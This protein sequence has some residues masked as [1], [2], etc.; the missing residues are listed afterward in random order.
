MTI[1]DHLVGWA[2]KVG[3]EL[4][5]QLKTETAIPTFLAK[6]HEIT[7]PPLHPLSSLGMHAQ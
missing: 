5:G 1:G 4:L 2:T 7:V 6:S 3:L